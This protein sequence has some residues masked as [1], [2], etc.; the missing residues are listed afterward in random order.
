MSDDLTEECNEIIWPNIVNAD[1]LNL[2]HMDLKFVALL[3]EFA[4]SLN[5]KFYM[6]RGAETTGH[7]PRSQHYKRPCQTA[8][9]YSKDIGLDRLFYW[10][11]TFKSKEGK[12]FGA[13]GAYPF[14]N[15]PGL[16]IDM[17]EDPVYWYRDRKG[18]YHYEF[19]AILTEQKLSEL[20]DQ[21]KLEVDFCDADF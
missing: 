7:S 10:A 18:K 3:N 11:H 17:R 5:T 13:I 1:K 19:E 9:F 4:G 6:N 16:H 21:V 14:W 15:N 8:D 12:T 20:V 2:E